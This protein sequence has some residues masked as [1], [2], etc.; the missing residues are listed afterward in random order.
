MKAKD[1]YKS[2][3]WKWF[4][5]YMKLKLA[6]NNHVVKCYTSG[7]FYQLPDKR[8]HLG[9]YIKVFNTTSTHLATAFD[10]RNVLTQSYQDNRYSSGK[11]D[12][13]RKELIRIH[14]ESNIENL[15]I[16]SKNFCKIDKFMLDLISMEYKQKFE[17][18]AKIK[19]NPW[20]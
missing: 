11:P 6:D 14:G 16:K 5:K 15:E 20:K 2:T 13:M 12:I 4:S 1:F 10:E 17:E 7:K 8:V 9:H 3:A 19:G 18:L